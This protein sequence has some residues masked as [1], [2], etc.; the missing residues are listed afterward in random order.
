MSRMP[1]ASVHGRFQPLHSAHL[2]YILAAKAKCAFLWIG[3]TKYQPNQLSP[4]GGHR[5]RQEANPLTYFE[6]AQ[7]IA[8]ALADAGVSSLEFA[9]TPFPI[10]TPDMLS[11]FLPTSIPCFT[12]IC[13]Q[14]NRDKIGLLEECGY[15]VHILWE[16]PK[17]TSASDIRRK[18]VEGGTDWKHLVPAATARAVERLDLRSRLLHLHQA[19]GPHDPPPHN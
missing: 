11:N 10:E 9:F 7:I 12:T 5:E 15:Q 19:A 18:I 3:L 14:W 13:E 1:V 8:E 4:L 16:R 6:R 2:E 17:T